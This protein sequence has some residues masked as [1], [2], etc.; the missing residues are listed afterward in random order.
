[1][2]SL[3]N[4]TGAWSKSNEFSINYDKSTLMTAG[5]KQRLQNIENVY[6]RIDS[7]HIPYSQKREIIKTLISNYRRESELDVSLCCDFF[8]NV[9]LEIIHL[10]CTRKYSDNFLS[11]PL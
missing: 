5:T 1:M 8:A 9:T 7:C 10:L 4:N 3:V 2:L 6:I 11:F